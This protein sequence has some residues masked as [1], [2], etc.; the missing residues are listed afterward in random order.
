MQVTK[1]DTKYDLYDKAYSNI[2]E[3]Y[4]SNPMQ[5]KKSQI[6]IITGKIEKIQLW[7]KIQFKIKISL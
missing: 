2:L 4:K 6:Q 3:A 7:M 5:D 1:L